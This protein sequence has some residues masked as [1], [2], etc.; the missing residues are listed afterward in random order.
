MDHRSIQVEYKRLESGYHY[1]RA[2][3]FHHLFAQ[4]PPG[5]RVGPFDVSGDAAAELIVELMEAAQRA[6]DSAS[7][8]QE[9]T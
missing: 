1:A 9:P 4:W 5:R 8:E 2:I 6:A 7:R 3:G